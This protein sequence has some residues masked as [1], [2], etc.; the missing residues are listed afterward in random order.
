MY[1]ELREFFTCIDEAEL[2]H[3]GRHNRVGV[4]TLALAFLALQMA[5]AANEIRRGATP[6]DVGLAMAAFNCAVCG[7]VWLVARRI[8]KVNPEVLILSIGCL[9]LGNLAMMGWAQSTATNSFLAYAPV[10][11]LALGGFLPWSPRYSLAM[12]ALSLVCLLLSTWAG[13]RVTVPLE[14]VIPITVGLGAGAAVAAQLRRH[15]WL[16]VERTNA[17]LVAAERMSS[18]GRMTAGVAHEL[19]T[20]L[21]AAANAASSLDA[22]GKELAA[23]IDHPHVTADDLREIVRE[24]QDARGIVDGSLRRASEF[25]QAIR[26]HTRATLSNSAEFSVRAAVDD[27]LGLLAHRATK[28][29]VAVDAAG[30]DPAVRLVGDAGKLQQIITNLVDNALDACAHRPDARVTVSASSEDGEV[31]LTVADDGPGVPSDLVKR[32]FEPLFTTKGSADGTGLGLSIS[33][34]LAESVLGGTLR[35]LPTPRGATFELRVPLEAPPSV[36]PRS[37]WTPRAAA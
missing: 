21:A 15:L 35:L 25:I 2:P 33:R 13:V 36:G 32:V 10:V 37:A 7:S 3:L 16:R 34:D 5:Y 20:P 14:V 6:L 1:R 30:V 27:A 9:L 19:K 22:L 24:M 26:A 29:G 17:Q 11:S 31:V 8:E 23:S 4:R 28:T 12:T 18:L